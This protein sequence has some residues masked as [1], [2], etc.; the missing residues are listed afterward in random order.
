[1]CAWNETG[2]IEKFYRDGPPAFDTGTVV[3]FAAVGEVETGA[4]ARY[5]EIADSAL[6]IDGRESGD[7][8]SKY[9]LARAWVERRS[10]IRICDERGT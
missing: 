1:V 6:R 10:S 3:G 8:L 7:K 9:A 5:L 4:W 2:D